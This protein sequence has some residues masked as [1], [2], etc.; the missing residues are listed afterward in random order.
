MSELTLEDLAQ[1]LNRNEYE[2]RM[3]WAAGNEK[4]DSPYV[5][6]RASGTGGD[7][8]EWR[9]SQEALEIASAYLAAEEPVN[10]SGNLAVCESCGASFRDSKDA[11]AIQALFRHVS[12]NHRIR[13]G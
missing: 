8:Y 11:D 3:N 4:P 13:R 12:A 5:F 6:S 10:A 1:I 7:G 9:S 2:G